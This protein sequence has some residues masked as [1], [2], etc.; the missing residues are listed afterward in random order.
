MPFETNEN[1]LYIN[2]PPPPYEESTST[3]LESLYEQEN[4]CLKQENELLKKELT[5]LK[6]NNLQ[7]KQGNNVL[8]EHSQLLNYQ[9]ELIKKTK[10]QSEDN[11]LMLQ[12]NH[13]LLQR[14]NSNL[15]NWLAIIIEREE[16]REAQSLLYLQTVESCEFTLN[17]SPEID[18]LR[19]KMQE[20]ETTLHSQKGE[21]SAEIEKQIEEKSQLIQENILE[22]FNQ[23]MHGDVYTQ[24]VSDLEV[25]LSAIIHQEQESFFNEISG[26]LTVPHEL[27]Q[28]YLD[29]KTKKLITLKQIREDE[30]SNLFYNTSYIAL[31]AKIIGVIS[32]FSQLVEKKA[33]AG[34]K[35]VGLSSSLIGGL[36]GSVPIVGAL[37][38]TVASFTLNELGEGVLDYFED[39]R[40]QNIL[41][42]LQNPDHA[43]KM[44]E[45]FARSLTLRYQN[46]IQ[47]W[48]SKTIKHAATMYSNQVYELST[49]GKVKDCKV[50]SLDEKVELFLS[51]LKTL[52]EREIIYDSNQEE[53]AAP[54]I[55]MSSPKTKLY[56]S[57]KSIKTKVQEQTQTLRKKVSQTELLSTHAS[58]HLKSV[59][60]QNSDLQ[61]ETLRNREEIISLKAE[62]NSLKTEAKRRDEEIND[63][64]SLISGLQE[65]FANWIVPPPEPSSGSEG[66][67]KGRPRSQKL[68]SFLNFF[69]KDKVSTS[70]LSRSDSVFYPTKY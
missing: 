25:K 42:I 65:I 62:V 31:W 50:Y 57:K 15:L 23:L 61:Q 19:L 14:E 64:K 45:L 12:S 53:T 68:G 27:T 6:Q 37:L 21:L 46:E 24:L 16:E 63:L 38:D 22:L 66:T 32:I 29:D 52:S 9:L 49:N 70:K 10:V 56:S 58:V 36:L 30:K 5:L 13:A 48:D 18:T 2:D 3:S 39:K 4:T 54:A 8:E 11:Y 41:A 55:A 60:R 1:D 20:L 33:G 34:K 44:A 59:Q 35:M 40:M 47:C 7:L 43:K 17:E 51:S 67:P 69:D 26:K 28:Q